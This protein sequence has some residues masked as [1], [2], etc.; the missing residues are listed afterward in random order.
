MTMRSHLFHIAILLSLP[1]A[2]LSQ[3][4]EETFER[5]NTLFREGKF[6]ESATT[7]ESILAQGMASAEIYFNL[8]NAY[9]R[10]GEVGRAVLNYERAAVLA[11]GDPDIEY[12]LEL[13]NL[14]TLDRLERVPEIFLLA[15]M[16]SAAALLPFGVLVSLGLAS[17][18]MTF[19][20][21]AALNVVPGR[22]LGSWIRWTV[23][24]SLVSLAIVGSLVL[25]QMLD[26]SADEEAIIIATVVT[27][28]TSPDAGSADAFVIHEGLK[29][30]I[31]DGVGDW[32]KITLSDGKVG[33][34]RSQ[35]CIRI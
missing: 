16:K 18:A 17:W 30:E 26:R 3:S 1:A 27:A 25:V 9:Y 34:I 8:G 19:L 13:A 22:V 15:W 2:V 28:K 32:L 31:G 5:G 24:A 33:W 35:E 4:V 11:P 20:A 23:L 12:N 7:Y 14:R 6:A 10:T 29:V 21:L